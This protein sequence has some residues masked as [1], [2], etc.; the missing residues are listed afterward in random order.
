MGRAA[1]AAR[2]RAGFTARFPGRWTLLV[3]FPLLVACGGVSQRLDDEDIPPLQY[4]GRLLHPAD[5]RA[6]VIDPG[7]LELDEA[8]AAFVARYTESRSSARQRLVS[9]HQALRG[10]GTLGLVYDPFAGGSARQV[11]H[12][13]S[14]NC[15]SYAH[16]LVALGRAAGLDARYQWVEARP[17]WTR[18]GE[19][20]AVRLHVNVLVA[21]SR[22]ERYMADIDPLAPQQIAGTRVLTDREAR[23]LHHANIAMERLAADDLEAAWLQ[24]VR[25][26]QLAPALPHLWTNLGVVYRHAGQHR[27]AELAY[28]QALDRDPGD[29]SAMSNLVVL[30]ELEGRVAE[31]DYWQQRVRRYREANPF[32]H[33]HLG[34]LAGER[35]DWAAA[36]A[37]YRRALALRPGDS[38]LLYATGLLHHRL[39]QYREADRLIGEAIAAAT[40]RRDR[41]AYQLR[42]RE[43]REERLATAGN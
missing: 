8:M 22:Q 20:V 40:L 25:A 42:L 2:G 32:Y 9:L 37:H 17:Q 41:E 11:F 19:Q 36:L 24:G 16:L 33:A 18:I 31:R 4:E 3:L 15:L 38:R 14:A 7:L 28:L 35:G 29:R 34:D 6:R 1:A 43:L 5:A 27:E 30:Y 12:R 23:A 39:G 26:L 21:L 10:G 13:G